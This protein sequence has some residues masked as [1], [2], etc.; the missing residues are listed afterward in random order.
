MSSLRSLTVHISKNLVKAGVEHVQGIAKFLDNNTLE[1]EGNT[2]QAEHILIATGSSPNKLDIPGIEH[3]ITSDEF[4][5]LREVPKRTIVVG[6]G[7]IG[8]YILCFYF[9][10]N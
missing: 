10:K 3:T 6:G 4:F 7:Y 2:Y 8:K 1:C 9:K 5:S